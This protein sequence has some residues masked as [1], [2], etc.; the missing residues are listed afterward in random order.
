M[1]DAVEA[2][3]K[4]AFKVASETATTSTSNNDPGQFGVK[5]TELTAELASTNENG[6]NVVEEA[7]CKYC[8]DPEF[9]D[10]LAL[11]TV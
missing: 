5:S 1:T 3:A 4:E 11:Q 10:R 7:E 6:T 8:I 2:A 9:S